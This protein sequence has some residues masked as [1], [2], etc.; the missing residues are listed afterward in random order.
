M[1]AP[2]LQCDQATRQGQFI[3]SPLE[4]HFFNVKRPHRPH[5]ALRVWH[6]WHLAHCIDTPSTSQLSPPHHHSPSRSMVVDSSAGRPLLASYPTSPPSSPHTRHTHTF[7]SRPRRRW[8]KPL[9][10]LAIPP[11]VLFIYTLAHPLI[12]SLPPLPHIRIETGESIPSTPSS[13]VDL[14]SPSSSPAPMMVTPDSCVCGSTER[15]KAL[16]NVYHQAGLRA[17]RI[18]QSSGARLRRVLGKARDGNDIRV[19]VLGGSG[20]ALTTN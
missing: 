5:R 20:E 6:I 2:T 8:I 19:G 11:L 10:L 17:S 16:C 9:I 4:R 18:V 3:L 14:T 7:T 12:P 15:G 1:S 13:D